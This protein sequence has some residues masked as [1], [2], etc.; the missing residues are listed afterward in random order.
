MIN[1]NLLIDLRHELIMS[2]NTIA[3]YILDEYID[4]LGDGESKPD[5]VSRTTI[6]K[7]DIFS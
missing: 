1:D 4:S 2:G 3:L 7:N 6:S 5:T